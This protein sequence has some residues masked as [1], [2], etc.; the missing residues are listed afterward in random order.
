MS[1]LTLRKT[2]WIVMTVLAL[3]IAAYAALVLFLPGFGPPFVQ[4]RR[5]TL[6]I[7]LY[8]HLAGGLLALAL[9]PWQFNA[10]IRDG[11]REVHRWMGRSYV[12]AVLVGG[13][14]GLAL[15]TRSMHG[16]VTH[17][18]FGVLAVCWLGTTLQAYRRI[19]AGDVVTHQRWM[20]R[21]Y[22]L[23]LAAVTLRIYL[24]ASAVAGLPFDVSYQVISWLCWVPNLL[25]AEWRFV[26]RATGA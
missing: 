18:G 20:I 19:R 14:G 15:A 17:L 8:A 24:P 5:A 16:W 12:V 1:A 7:A 11:Y 21:S 3:A 10:R 4:D 2:G 13:T 22:A 6:P 26:P 25:V 23:T 9:G